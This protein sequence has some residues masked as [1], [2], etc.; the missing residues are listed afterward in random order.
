VLQPGG[1]FG[2]TGIELGTRGG[3]ER[4]RGEEVVAAN[5]VAEGDEEDAA[6]QAREAEEEEDS[7]EVGAEGGG[8]ALGSQ[9]WWVAIERGHKICG[10]CLSRGVV[11]MCR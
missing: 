2:D 8:G 4:M 7:A 1:A 10:R 11:K 3:I 9:R 5:Q 6:G